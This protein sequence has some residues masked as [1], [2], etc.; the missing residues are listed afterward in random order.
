MMFSRSGG[1]DV[2]T[3][4]AVSTSQNFPHEWTL[5]PWIRPA[6]RED[7]FIRPDWDT[8][9]TGPALIVLAKTTYPDNGAFAGIDSPE[10][11]YAVI[12]E[13]LS[14]TVHP[15]AKPAPAPATPST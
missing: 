14:G 2:A 15:D 11:A 4:D 12:S 8:A 9:V 7:V 10:K 13:Y 5:K 1:I 3:V 6:G